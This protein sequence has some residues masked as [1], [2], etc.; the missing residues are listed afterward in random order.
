MICGAGA[1]RIRT[2]L[3]A[4]WLAG[5]FAGNMRGFLFQKQGVNQVVFD[6]K[7]DTGGDKV[8]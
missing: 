6:G 5:G 7:Q 4:L 8:Q 2:E 1:N 3:C